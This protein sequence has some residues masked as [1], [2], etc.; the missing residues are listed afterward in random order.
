GEFEG[1]PVT[2]S[3][4]PEPI[5]S[6][7]HQLAFD[8]PA[9]SADPTCVVSVGRVEFDDDEGSRR[10][11][12]GLRRGNASLVV[13]VTDPLADRWGAEVVKGIDAAD[14]ELIGHDETEWLVRSYGV[15]VRITL[16]HGHPDHVRIAS[17]VWTGID[18]SFELLHEINQLNSASTG[19][20]FVV[21][22]GDVWVVADIPC[23]DRNQI[24]PSVTRVVDDIVTQTRRYAPLLGALVI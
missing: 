8:T 10:R 4:L 7:I 3:V 14:V 9:G 11:A 18:E 6:F 23:H 20:R 17:A 12:I 15:D 19:P 2:V 13:W 16:H 22:D 21:A 24:A 1:D 5:N